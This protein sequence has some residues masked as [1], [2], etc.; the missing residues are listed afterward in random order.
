MDPQTKSQDPAIPRRRLLGLL[1]VML[2][3]GG[4]LAT[5]LHEREPVCRGKR[6]SEWLQ[7]LVLSGDEQ[8]TM[9]AEAAIRQIGTNGIPFLLKWIQYE[10]RGGNRTMRAL[11]DKIPARLRSNRLVYKFMENTSER[12]AGEAEMGLA[13]LGPQAAPAIPDL[14]RQMRKYAAT[15]AALSAIRSLGCI[16]SA[17]LPVLM[18]AVDEPQ[19]PNRFAAVATI[20]MN[21]RGTNGLPA[22]PLLVRSAGDSDSRVARASILALGTLHLEPQTT[23]PALTNRVHDPRPDI[24]SAAVYAL[25]GFKQQASE[26][27]PVLAE[28]LKDLDVGVRLEAVT[29]AEKFKD[30]VP[31]FTPL[32]IEATKD[33]NQNVR[34]AANEAVRSGR[35]AAQDIE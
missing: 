32:L 35:A 28:A 29:V 19:F 10:P 9:S 26:L 18:A 30:R 6:L 3:G 15:N 14:T 34:A 24:R 25:G 8:E 7:L 5:W 33:T 20:A 21:F 13:I 17:A 31:E 22:L 16:G 12:R 4:S 23:I 11:V 1:L 27:L 2:V